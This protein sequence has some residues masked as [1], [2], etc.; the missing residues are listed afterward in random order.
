MIR[1][2]VNDKVWVN[3]SHVVNHLSTHQC[4]FLGIEIW[5]HAGTVNRYE[6]VEECKSTLVGEILD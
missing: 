1:C 4:W 2:M 3:G 6:K 5:M